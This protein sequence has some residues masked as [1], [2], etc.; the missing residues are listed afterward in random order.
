MNNPRGKNRDSNS[1]PDEVKNTDGEK[2][3][4]T[5]EEAVQETF[6]LPPPPPQW[7]EGTE[8]FFRVPDVYHLAPEFFDGHLATSASL[9]DINP[10]NPAAGFYGMDW[11]LA[12][13]IHQTH[14]LNLQTQTRAAVP[15]VLH[16]RINNIHQ[17]P[18]GKRR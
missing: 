8:S 5:P 18:R 16:R 14:I 2:S 7:N 9:V 3:T 6:A 17:Y 12:G 15:T 10:V 13:L 1:T 11:S 4:V